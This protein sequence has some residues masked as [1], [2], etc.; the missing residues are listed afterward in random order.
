MEIDRTVLRGFRGEL[1]GAVE[2]GAM[3]MF[4]ARYGT[5]PVAGT[6]RWN[7]PRPAVDALPALRAAQIARDHIANMLYEL[8]CRARAEAASW[9][10]IG[11]HL[12]FTATADRTAGEHAFDWLI[13]NVSGPGCA[14]RPSWGLYGP[15]LSWTCPDCTELIDDHGPAAGHPDEQMH[16]HTRTCRRRADAVRAYEQAHPAP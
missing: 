9:Q 1:T 5:G 7:A 6:A 10:A 13:H 11:E 12:G 16:G 15:T 8:A 2:R 14:E 4:G 3:T